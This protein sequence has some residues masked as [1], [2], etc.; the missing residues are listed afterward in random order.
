MRKGWQG[1]AGNPL[2][3][4]PAHQS[5]PAVPRALSS[6][7]SSCLT[8]KLPSEGEMGRM[9]GVRTFATGMLTVTWSWPCSSCC[10]GLKSQLRH[11]FLPPVLLLLVCIAGAIFS[12]GTVSSAS[13]G[14]E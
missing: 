4:A 2:C 12:G 6:L 10:P 14:V 13:A 8:Q 7:P 9:R 1:S 11:G 5:E 3:S